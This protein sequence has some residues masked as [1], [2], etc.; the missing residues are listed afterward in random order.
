MRIAE[1]SRSV[2]K[3]SSKLRRTYVSGCKIVVIFSNII[4]V[5]SPWDSCCSFT[6]PSVEGCYH[7]FASNQLN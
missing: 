3:I 2:Y 7:L 4:V 5:D 1:E 6:P